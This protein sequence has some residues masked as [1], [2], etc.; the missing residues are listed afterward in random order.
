MIENVYDKGWW[1]MMVIYLLY[2]YRQSKLVE[3][4][5]SELVDMLKSPLSA[6]ELERM[7]PED[8]AA[9]PDA[10]SVLLNTFTQRNTEALVKCEYWYRYQRPMMTSCQ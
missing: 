1:N 2:F 8:N 4:A 7:M 6:A 10:Y 3:S 9:E 5:V